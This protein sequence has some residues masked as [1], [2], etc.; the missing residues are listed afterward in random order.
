[1][2]YQVQHGDPFPPKIP[3]GPL[4][5]NAW[6]TVQPALKTLENTGYWTILPLNYI[7][8]KHMESMERLWKCPKISKVTAPQNTRPPWAHVGHFNDLK[9]AQRTASSQQPSPHGPMPCWSDVWFLISE[10]LAWPPWPPWPVSLRVGS[11]GHKM[12][13]A[14]CELCRFMSF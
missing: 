2:N 5:K 12:W 3:R 6:P 13:Q 1:M 7:A 11:R 14:P 8:M 10:P 4:S 9:S